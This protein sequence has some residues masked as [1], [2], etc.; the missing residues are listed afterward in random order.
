MQILIFRGGGFDGC[1][2]Q[3]NCMVKHEDEWKEVYVSGWRGKEA[4]E[5]GPDEYMLRHDRYKPGLGLVWDLFDT[6]SDFDMS[7]MLG[8]FNASMIESF[9]DRITQVT[10]EEEF[11]E[12]VGCECQGEDHEEDDSLI[13]WSSLFITKDGR[14]F[15]CELCSDKERMNGYA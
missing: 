7:G 2:W 5:M 12:H 14:D 13:H 6:D 1:W 10:G 9:I 11:L 15:I 8:S 4:L 3:W